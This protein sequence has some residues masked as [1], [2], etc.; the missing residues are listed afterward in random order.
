MTML[1]GSQ[2]MLICLSQHRWSIAS[3]RPRSCSAFSH[4]ARWSLKMLVTLEAGCK[5]GFGCIRLHLYKDKG[6]LG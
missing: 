2:G 3:R 1:R 4:L 6:Y 5:K